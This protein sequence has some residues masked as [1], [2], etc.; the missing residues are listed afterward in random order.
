MVGIA[1]DRSAVVEM[2]VAVEREG[3]EGKKGFLAFRLSPSIAYAEIDV[4]FL[5][6]RVLR[7]PEHDGRLLSLQVR[8]EWDIQRVLVMGCVVA[9]QT[10]SKGTIP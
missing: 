3:V 8:H 6:V 10:G 1:A 4:H 7:H 2:H 9:D 5:E